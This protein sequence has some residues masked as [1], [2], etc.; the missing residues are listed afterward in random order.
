MAEEEE[1]QDKSV[2]RRLTEAAATRMGASVIDEG[3]LGELQ[4]A[5]EDRR[6]L[7]KELDALAW[8]SLDYMGGNEQD[9]QAVKRRRLAQQARIAWQQDAQLGAAVD[10]RNNFVFGRG[11][12]KPKA[13]DAK[14]QQVIDEAW[15]DPDN[16]LILTSYPAQMALGT[17]LTLQS[18]LFILM[19]A[20]QDG[21]VKLGMLDHDSVETVVR[22]PDNRRKILYYVSRRRRLKWDFKLDQPDLDEYQN[23][24]RDDVLYYKHWANEP[25]AGSEAPASKV[26]EGVVY[27]VAV[28]RGSE[29]AFGHPRMHR[30]LRW[31]TAFNGLMEARVDAAK[32]Q[33][34]F[35]MKRKVKGTPNQVRKMA[36]QILSKS[37][38][39]GRASG[40][41]DPMAGPR[42]GSILTENEAV[43]HE[44]FNLDSGAQSANVDGQ[45]IRSQISA[46]TGFPQH[47]LGDIGSAN[48][49][50]ATSMELPVLKSVESDQEVVEQMIRWFID[51]VIEQA[52]KGGRLDAEYD[53][54]EWAKLEADRE[55]EGHEEQADVAT[56]T[57]AL[58]AKAASLQLGGM[59]QPEDPNRTRD[60]SYEFSLPNPLR[61]MMGDLVNAVSTIARTFDPNGTNLELSRMLL[62]VALGEGLEAEDPA[63]VVRK[64]FPPGYKDPAMAALQAQQAAQGAPGAPGEA[65]EGSG[66]P[67]VPEG[68][69]APPGGLSQNNSPASAEAPAN[70]PQPSTGSPPPEEAM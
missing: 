47:Y 26:G 12:P 15:K 18:N 20:G 5:A 62:A 3:D 44:S 27:H 58:G 24:D 25:P 10:L 53:D 14:V 66:E 52:I 30:V 21:R 55:K 36:T 7:R 61:R 28:N 17:D 51:R 1:T 43:E 11:V 54:E 56:G 16:Q 35:I 67:Q 8:A 31:A 4:E 42:G 57:E 38:E 23:R 6:L 39:L 50:T 46:G 49:A 34:A 33:A 65:P 29:M 70:M 9:L 63:A 69:Y 19:F 45:M 2:L 40:T 48:L 22:D 13:H 64:V 60:L 59:A 68:A 32:A 37:G 41:D